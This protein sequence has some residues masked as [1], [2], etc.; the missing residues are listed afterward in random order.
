[1]V[2]SEEYPKT[3]AEAVDRLHNDISLNDEVLLATLN[4][5]DLVNV[6][7]SLGQRIREEF[8]LWKG[9]NALLESCRIMAGT[10]DIHVDDASMVIVRA[11]WDKVKMS[12]VLNG[13]DTH[14]HTT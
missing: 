7:F 11:L 8:G 14:G 9:N 2:I 4:E 10:E 6:H 1:M 12:N 13:K 3:I 5:E